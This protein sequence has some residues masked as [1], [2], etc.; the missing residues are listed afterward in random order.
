MTQPFERFPWML[1]ALKESTRAERLE[2]IL[3]VGQA[4]AREMNLD[5]LLSVILP[6]I[7]RA[8]ECDRTTIFLI[9]YDRREM[10]SKIAEGVARIRCPLIGSLAGYVATTGEIVNIA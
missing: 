3:I 6:L 5:R 10:W 1:Q 2:S 8:M 4:I 9:D 7:S